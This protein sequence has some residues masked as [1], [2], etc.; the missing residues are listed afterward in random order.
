MIFK[1]R[2]LRGV[3]AAALAGAVAL[4]LGGLAAAAPASPAAYSTAPPD[5]SGVW[6]LDDSFM[7]DLHPAKPGPRGLPR[8]WM[9]LKAYAKPNEPPPLRP[10]ILAKVAA[11]E[12][13]ELAGRVMDPRTAE[14]KYANIFDMM[15]WTS[16]I[17]IYQRWNELVMIVE[18][19]RSLPRHVYIGHKH[20]PTDELVPTINGH[21]VAHWEGDTLVVDTVGFDP[22]PWFM[23]VDFIPQSEDLHV[24]ERLRLKDPQ[25]LDATWTVTDPKVFTR[26]WVVHLTYRKQPAGTQLFEAWCNPED[27]GFDVQK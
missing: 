14:C 7:P 16:P 22:G 8:A 21:S 3:A 9:G 27:R 5:F 6:R 12:K 13:Q 25:T 1:A 20:P 11:E 23:L 18:R 15:S 17:D 4:G 24:V 10:E 19:E 26:P 2:S